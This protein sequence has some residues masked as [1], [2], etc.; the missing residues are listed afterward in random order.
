M[1]KT[2]LDKNTFKV[3]CVLHLT[4]TVHFEIVNKM[5][6]AKWKVISAGCGKCSFLVWEVSKQNEIVLKI[7]VFLLVLKK[8]MKTETQITF[9][10]MECMCLITR[11]N[12]RLKF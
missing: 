2:S 3:K 11:G 8:K 7:F 5:A 12:I 10:Q 1:A 9:F 4:T 6:Y